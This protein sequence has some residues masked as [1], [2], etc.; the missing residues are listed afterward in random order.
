[1]NKVEKDE[2]ERWF[3]QVLRQP[4]NAHGDGTF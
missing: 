3:L 2:R 1:M 4:K